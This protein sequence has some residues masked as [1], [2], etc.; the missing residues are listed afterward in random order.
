MVDLKIQPYYF[1]TPLIKVKCVYANCNL[2]WPHELLWPIECSRHDVVWGY[3]SPHY[4]Q[5]GDSLVEVASELR[6]LLETENM[7]IIKFLTNLSLVV[8]W[9]M[10]NMPNEFVYMVK[11]ILKQN[12]ENAIYLLWAVY[13]KLQKQKVD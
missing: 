7:M 8:T 11:Q 4:R 13:S 6:K 5:Q 10:E 2:A 1:L 9:T 3:N 12:I